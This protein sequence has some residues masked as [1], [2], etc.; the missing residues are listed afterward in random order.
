LGRHRNRRRPDAP[1]RKAR[2]KLTCRRVARAAARG[3]LLTALA[4][5][6]VAGGVCTYG[7]ALR[8]PQL[9]LTKITFRGLRQA[10][11][12][13]LIQ[14]SG[15]ALGENIFRVDLAGLEQAIAAHPWVR[16]VEIH[17]RI[18]H[19]LLI[20]V[21]EFKPIAK[22]SLGQLYL[23]DAD[24]RP[25]KRVQPSD[26][27][28]LPLV[29]GIG[30]EQYLREPETTSARLQQA[31]EMI[32]DYRRFDPADPVSELKLEPIGVTL[33][34]QSGVEIDFGEGER[35]AKFARLR[36]IRS[37]LSRRGLWAQS[38]RLDNRVRPG[39]IAVRPSRGSIEGGSQGIGNRE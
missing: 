34:S 25:F 10:T 1:Q 21:D 23:L 17:R 9:A 36:R 12:A 32:A 39:W 5:G 15:L 26:S 13:E 30:R 8:S 31:A 6:A 7:W 27:A 2:L 14:L 4:A 33:I 18:P 35:A 24:G 3:L 16:R 20:Q 22:V 37:E 19:E 11:E 28:D 38:I 29:T